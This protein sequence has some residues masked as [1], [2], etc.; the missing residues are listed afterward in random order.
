MIALAQPMHAAVLRAMGSAKNELS[1]NQ[2]NASRVT[3]T[4]DVPV[5]M[6][7]RSAGHRASI[8]RAVRAISGSVALGPIAR[9][10]LGRVVRDAGQNRVPL[11]PARMRANAWAM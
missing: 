9:T 1:G 2:G 6:Y 4:S 5:A 11:P 8:R 3:A 7:A 10:C